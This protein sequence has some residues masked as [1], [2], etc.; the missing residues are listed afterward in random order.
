MALLPHP[1]PTPSTISPERNVLMGGVCPVY[2]GLD[3]GSTG[4]L[5]PLLWVLS[6]PF[7]S[8]P[9]HCLLCHKQ[10]LTAPA[11]ICS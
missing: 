10:Q 6:L 11:N 2:L 4:S 3:M 8:L 1:P 7:C 9:I 5:G